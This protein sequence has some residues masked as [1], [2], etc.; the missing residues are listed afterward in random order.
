MKDKIKFPWRY[1]EQFFLGNLDFNIAL[2]KTIDEFDRRIY[3]HIE[4]YGI[5]EKIE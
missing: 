2:D 5:D 4:R 3:E 1:L